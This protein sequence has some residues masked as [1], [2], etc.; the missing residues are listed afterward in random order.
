MN[1]SAEYDINTQIKRFIHS[2]D[3]PS[4]EYKYSQP[5]QVKD[6]E[7]HQFGNCN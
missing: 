4:L 5:G 7:Q 1:A 3:I 2:Y 6:I